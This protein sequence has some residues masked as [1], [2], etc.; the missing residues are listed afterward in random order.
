MST[1]C[2]VT[3]PNPVT[4][5]HP[6]RRSAPLAW[7]AAGMF[8]VIGFGGAAAAQ[9]P[10]S[11]T[12][13]VPFQH[14]YDVV[15]RGIAVGTGVIT[16]AEESNGCYSYTNATRPTAIVRL[17]TGSPV[18][19]SRFCVENGHLRPVAFHYDGGKVGEKSFDL[20]FSPDARAVNGGAPGV[21]KRQ[22]PADAVDFNALQQVVRLWAKQGAAGKLTV[23]VVNADDTTAYQFAR[24]GTERLTVAGGNFET[25]R[26]ERV[27]SGAEGKKLT[28]W[29]APALDDMAVKVMEER[30]GKTRFMISLAKGG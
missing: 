20:Q 21:G 13:L 10:P 17:I 27:G 12:V 23:T 24:V 8:L 3:C 16:L 19:S 14:T 15:I 5:D 22:L 29:V 30:D 25:V 9:A 18:E 11:P 6:G 2:L 28:F 26:I 4:G 7:L 1:H